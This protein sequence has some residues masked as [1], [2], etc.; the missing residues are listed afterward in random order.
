MGFDTTDIAGSIPN[1]LDGLKTAFGSSLVGLGTSM[2]INLFFVESID[3]NEKS[4]AEISKRLND[5]NTRLEKFTVDSASANVDALMAAMETMI[6]QLEVGINTETHD[7]MKKFRESVITLHEWQSQYID[8]IKNVTD[9]MDRNAEVTRST[10]EQL[11]RTNDVLAELGP[12]TETIAQ[13]IGWVQKALPSF[14]PKQRRVLPEDEA[15]D[16]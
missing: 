4:L 5:L 15:S 6:K 2:L 1:L 11:D 16:E 7:V 13:S 14:R 10:T 3:T 12:V 8:E 9:A